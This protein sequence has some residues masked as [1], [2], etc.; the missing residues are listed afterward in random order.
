M[1]DRGE[2]TWQ[3]WV[4]EDLESGSF[5]Q[6]TAPPLPERP[7]ES[8]EEEWQAEL[9][10]LRQETRQ[11]AF[12]QG[13][14][15]GRAKGESEGSKQGYDDGFEQG[16]QQGL[17]QGAAQAMAEQQEVTDR[18]NQFF[19]AFNA[20]REAAG[21]V[22]PAVLMQI[23]LSAARYV[24]GENPVCDHEALLKHIRQM[25]Q[26][27]PLHDGEYQLAVH[28]DDLSFLQTRLGESCAQQRWTLVADI[29]V[30]QGGCRITGAEGDVDATMDARW[31]ML[32][33]LAREN[34]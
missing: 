18:L 26:E 19:H 13:L 1:S 28:P 25:M 15:E 9:V 11:Q 10:R 34:A 14:A 20:T 7:Q 32:C 23:A 2:E 5:A 17:E 30:G 21:R 12:E 4:L 16:R 29:T 8:S 3:K 31:Q 6:E 22:M 27:S 24:I 33:T